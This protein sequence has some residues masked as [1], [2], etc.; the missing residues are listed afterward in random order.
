[1]TDFPT[2]TQIAAFL[3]DDANVE[4]LTD[5]VQELNNIC[6]NGTSGLPPRGI[7]IPDEW[8][9]YAKTQH[10]GVITAIGPNGIITIRPKKS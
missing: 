9:E 8:A 2:A 3:E 6:I 10:G 7:F 5:A 1:M 4:A